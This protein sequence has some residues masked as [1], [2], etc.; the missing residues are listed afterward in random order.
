MDAKYKRL[1]EFVVQLVQTAQQQGF[2]LSS[3]T[4]GQSPEYP[5]PIFMVDQ[6]RKVGSHAISEFDQ[7]KR[8]FEQLM[9]DDVSSLPE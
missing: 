3:L 1:L 8:P 7:S 4:T 6:R 2:Q 9:R 5:T